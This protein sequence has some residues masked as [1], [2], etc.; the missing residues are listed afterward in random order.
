MGVTG[1]CLRRGGGENCFA[2]RRVDYD[3]DLI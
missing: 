1:T 3:A 2:P